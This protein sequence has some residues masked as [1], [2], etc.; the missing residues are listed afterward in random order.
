MGVNPSKFAFG[1]NF[2]HNTN[3]YCISMVSLQEKLKSR[4]INGDVPLGTEAQP[5][6]PERGVLPVETEMR[7]ASPEGVHK[8]ITQ[9]REQLDLHV[10]VPD[11][12]GSI[13]NPDAQLVAKVFQAPAAQNRFMKVSPTDRV[14]M[15]LHADKLDAWAVVGLLEQQSRS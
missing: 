11:A 12:G 2:C 7:A 3:T 6:G 15:L 13:P 5:V 9:I 10:K 1:V 14:V 8:G 4:E